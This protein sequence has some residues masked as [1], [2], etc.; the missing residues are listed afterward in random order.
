MK[1]ILFDS[2]TIVNLDYSYVQMIA[3]VSEIHITHRINAV[4]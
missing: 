3:P 1:S 4:D 2:L